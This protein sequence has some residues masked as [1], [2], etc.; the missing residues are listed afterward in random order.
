M[1]SLSE[2]QEKI[3]EHIRLDDIENNAIEKKLS[4][5]VLM[6]PHVN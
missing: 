5:L 1:D 6:T 4:R 2:S 3:S